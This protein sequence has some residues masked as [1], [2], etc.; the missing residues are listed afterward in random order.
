MAEGLTRYLEDNQAEA[1]R[2]ID[3]CLTSRKAREAARRAREMVHPK[4]TRMDGSSLPGK[5]SDCSGTGPVPVRA[6]RRRGRVR[7]AAPPRWAGTGQFQAI[8]PLKGKNPERRES[9]PATG[10]DDSPTRRSSA[11]VSAIGAGEG[12]EFQTGEDA[13]PQDHHHDRRRRGR[14][15]HPHP[16]T[17]VHLQTDAR[18]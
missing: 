12:P 15:P 4:R 6:L 3:K 11:L 10:E 18:P 17:D 14:L 13:V 9:A 1:K 2:I 16:D 7:R 8:L 5:L